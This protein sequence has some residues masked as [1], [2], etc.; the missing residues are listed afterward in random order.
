LYKEN[1]EPWLQR[2]VSKNWE[3]VALAVFG[4]FFPLIVNV[5]LSW[6]QRAKKKSG[7][8]KHTAK[9]AAGS[10]VKLDNLGK[11]QAKMEAA[12]QILA[13]KKRLSKFEE[14]YWR[15]KI[16][17]FRSDLVKEIPRGGHENREVFDM[18]WK[19][20][21]MLEIDLEQLVRAGAK[22]SAAPVSAPLGGSV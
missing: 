13:G 17:E 21:G 18:P 20:L 5:Y 14:G 1:R 7:Q 12:E 6:H 9:T 4:I 10:T 22:E 8:T 3:A 2:L 11:L 19:L 15:Q 16:G